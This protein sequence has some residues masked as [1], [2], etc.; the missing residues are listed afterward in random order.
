MSFEI[1]G[2]DNLGAVTNESVQIVNLVV[3]SGIPITSTATTLV[4]NIFGKKRLISISGI[5]AGT[6][7]S[8]ATTSIKINAFIADVEDWINNGKQVRRSVQDSFGNIYSCICTNF[9]WTKS[10]KNPN[11]LLYTMTFIEGGWG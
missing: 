7:Y 1:T 9:T 3:Q 2:I 6:G 10:D 11:I 5:T 4:S 8:G